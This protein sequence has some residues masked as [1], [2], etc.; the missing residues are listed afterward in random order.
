[1]AR[2]K[3]PYK[4]STPQVYLWRMVL[5]VIL[6]CFLVFMEYETVIEAFMAN[7]ILNGL[8]I[9]VGVC[10]IV[11]AVLMVAAL[12][13]EIA[14]V[15]RFRTGQPAGRRP[16]VLLAPMATLLRD[17]VEETVM[18]P[19]TMRAMLDTI[20]LRLD[21]KRDILRYLIGLLVFLGLL[22]TFYGL[23]QTVG[24]VGATIQS[25]DVTSGDSSVIF[26]NLKTGLEAPLVGMGT[27]F[28]S[29]LFG[30]TGSLV[31]GFLDLQAGQAQNRFYTEL[32][33]WLSTLTDI[34]DDMEASGVG[35]ATLDLQ[36]AVDRLTQLMG[37]INAGGTADRQ[38]AKALGTLAEGIQAIVK[39]TRRE[40]KVLIDWAEAQGA[41]NER[42]EELLVRLNR[43][44]EADERA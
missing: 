15:N 33:D 43:A 25:L 35:Q 6:V 16:P 27:A 36:H 20:G 29:S 28:S 10:G 4:L 11:L 31:V 41:Q 34:V 18:S 3:D 42:I 9:A 19:V 26:Q 2:K 21:E 1:M 24:S 13:R 44:L 40:Q 39:N 12:F 37:T 23:L 30:L 22:G 8:I 38:T 7:P 14:W 17:G 32:E 5:F